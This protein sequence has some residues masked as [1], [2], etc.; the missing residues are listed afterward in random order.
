MIY[1]LNGQGVSLPDRE[2]IAQAILDGDANLLNAHVAAGTI[3]HVGDD[4]DPAGLFCI[5]C[6]DTLSVVHS[7]RLFFRHRNTHD[8]WNSDQYLGIL[9]PP[10]HGW[11]TCPPTTGPV[12]QALRR[13]PFR[14]KEMG[15]WKRG[16]QDSGELS[17]DITRCCTRTRPKRK[18]F[19]VHQGSAVTPSCIRSRDGGK[20]SVKQW[21]ASQTVGTDIR[22]SKGVEVGAL[23]EPYRKRFKQ[24]F[25]ADYK[26]DR[27]PWGSL[28][29]WYV[30]YCRPE[31]GT[32]NCD[33]WDEMAKCLEER[34]QMYEMIL[35]RGRVH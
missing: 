20:L 8:C 23:M 19:S 24:E 21:L 2:A 28:L 7:T 22:G 16:P 25:D 6:L 33:R 17:G 4:P 9:N 18:S 35:A 5:Y 30:T 11:V 32:R 14:H 29:P 27:C 15:R 31:G 3:V 34:R 10:S 12:A 13:L 1:A 26:M